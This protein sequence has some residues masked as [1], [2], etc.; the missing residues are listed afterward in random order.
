MEMVKL[1]KI[2]KDRLRTHSMRSI[3]TRYLGMNDLELHETLYCNFRK[4]DCILL[5]S[6]ALTNMIEKQEILC[7]LNQSIT[8]GPQYACDTLISE[9]N[10]NGGHDNTTVIMIQNK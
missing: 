9:A 3:V 7:L 10:N 6:D 5:C 4:E 2:G 1:G 8:M